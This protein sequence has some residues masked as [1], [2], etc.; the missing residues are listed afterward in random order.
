MSYLSA[1]A[2]RAN[3][4]CSS[5]VPFNSS[6]GAVAWNALADHMIA[7]THPDGG[8][9][10]DPDCKCDLGVGG[11]FETPARLELGFLPPFAYD[12]RRVVVHVDDTSY[13][14]DG[15]FFLKAF[16]P[17]V[18]VLTA[19]LIVLFAA[20]KLLDRR[21]VPRRQET[22]EI[23]PSE[24]GR[25]RRARRFLLKN[26]TLFRMR[27]ALQSVC[28]SPTLSST[29]CAQTRQ[30]NVLTC[31]LV[32]SLCSGSNYRPEQLPCRG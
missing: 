3:I 31:F 18:W 17:I 19:V 2:T 32:M 8:L 21:F 1:L 6:S 28:K 26:A 7:C 9:R 24:R 15:G 29:A 25:F 12:A 27:R 16:D 11:W 23:P 4:S 30:Q 20:L 10:D 22:V 13:S 14:T 5:V